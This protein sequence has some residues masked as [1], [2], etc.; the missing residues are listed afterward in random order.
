MPVILGYP[1]PNPLYGENYPYVEGPNPAR[2][3][4]DPYS[5][6]HSAFDEGISEFGV[7][8]LWQKSHA[9]PCTWYP[10]ST[11]PR[12]TP[13]P[14]CQTC[15]G[16]GWYW[17]APV[18]PVPVLFTYAHSPLAADEPGTIMDDKMGQILG[19]SPLITVAHDVNY[20]IWQYASEFDK[21]TEIDATWRFNAN[22]DSSRNTTLPYTTNVIVSPTGAVTTYNIATSSVV[23][24]SGYTVNGST[25]TLPSGYAYGTPYMV[26]FFAN[27][28]F[29]TFKR[30]GGMP[31]ARP[32]G[33][34]NSDTPVTPLPKRFRAAPLDLWIRE[35][36]NF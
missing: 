13:Q 18:G 4:V 19:A 14:S 31:H 1:I 30:A 6:Q 16:L 2:L 17:D 11:T 35:R 26:E 27:P 32:F 21:W 34:Y 15:S 23:S 33:G 12:G 10:T 29:I 9:C 8:M 3:P 28:V 22:L 20:E 36:N 7:R 24:V 25:V 5:L